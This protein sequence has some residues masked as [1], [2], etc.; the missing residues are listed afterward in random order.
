MRVGVIRL[1]GVAES[2][3]L[4]ACRS[5]D[6]LDVVA[7]CDPDDH[8]R[9]LI[10]ARFSIPAVYLTPQLVPPSISVTWC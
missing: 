3:H 5:I 10:A 8:R 2:I 6:M 4:P 7:A 9:S 1:G